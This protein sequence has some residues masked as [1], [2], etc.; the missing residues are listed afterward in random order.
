MECV[1][2]SQRHFVRH[3]KSPDGNFS[4]ETV[5]M[6]GKTFF[7]KWY[8]TFLIVVQKSDFNEFGRVKSKLYMIIS[9]K[10]NSLF[11]W[12]RPHNS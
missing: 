2:L 4:I 5:C 7:S 10:P 12:S 8:L 9:Y 1:Y 3:G 6:W 11:F